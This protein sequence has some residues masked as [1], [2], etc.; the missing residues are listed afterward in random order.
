MRDNEKFNSGVDFRYYDDAACVL[1]T[2]FLEARAPHLNVKLSCLPWSRTEQPLEPE[3]SNGMTRQESAVLAGTF[4]QS[5]ELRC[6]IA[7]LRQ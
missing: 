7:I 5:E 1:R 6:V 2:M 3:E 4:G